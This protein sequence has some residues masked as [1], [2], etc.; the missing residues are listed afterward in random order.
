M[1]ELPV[2]LKKGPVKFRLLVQLPKEGDAINN[3]SIAWPKDRPL[4][5]LGTMTLTSV[6]KDSL[7]A[8]QALDFNPLVLPDGIE[9]SADPVLIARPGAYGYSVKRRHQEK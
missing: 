3:G 2:R 9:A 8:Q 5:E 7:A 1:D 6:A 4:V